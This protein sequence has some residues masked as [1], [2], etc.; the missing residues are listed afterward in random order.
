MKQAFNELMCNCVRFGGVWTRFGVSEW[1]SLTLVVVD[2]TGMDRC[3]G[4]SSN[5]HLTNTFPFPISHL[6]KFRL[7]KGLSREEFQD[8]LLLHACS[9]NIT[10]SANTRRTGKSHEKLCREKF[11]PL[12]QFQHRNC[13]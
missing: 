3:H 12:Q 7:I 11:N 5:F 1:S 6:I 9:E 10:N 4:S 8:N 2:E 13:T